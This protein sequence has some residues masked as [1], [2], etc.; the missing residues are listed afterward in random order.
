MP[1]I[2]ILFLVDNIA[3]IFATYDKIKIYRSAT[4]AGV[5]TAISSMVAL[6]SSRTHYDYVDT[7]APSIGCWYKRS[8]YKSTVP[9]AESALSDPFQGSLVV[10]LQDIRNEGLTEGELSNDRALSLSAGWQS[11]FEKKCGQWF[12]PRELDLLLDGDGSRVLHLNVPVISVTDLFVNDDFVNALDP[13]YYVVYNRLFPEDDRRNPR[14]K[15]KRSSGDI[16]TS[17]TGST[18]NAGDQNQKIS[19]MF[20]YVEE[21]GSPPFAVMRAILLLIRMTAAQMNDDEVDQLRV[22]RATEEVTDRHRI[23]YSDLYDSLK[24]W[25]VTGITE[26]DDALVTY[27]RPAKIRSPRLFIS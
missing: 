16:F 18:F 12:T 21:D 11:W 14:I 22:G 2:K 17:Y 5:Y 19:G 1:T 10:S 23:R 4:Y 9:T 3:S 8:F 24:K 26:V 25:S 20:G 27:R 6:E 7:E 15:I 13:S